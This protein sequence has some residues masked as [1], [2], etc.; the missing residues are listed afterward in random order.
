[1]PRPE[2]TKGVSHRN[3]PEAEAVVGNGSEGSHSHCRVLLCVSIP[4]CVCVF[5]LFHSGLIHLVITP[6]HRVI[7]GCN[8]ESGNN[9][10]T[11]KPNLQ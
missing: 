8:S 4:I 9:P 2:G 3:G 1:M 7:G 5:V 10:M 6:L 11:R